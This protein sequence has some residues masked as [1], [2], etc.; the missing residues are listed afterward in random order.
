MQRFVSYATED[1]PI[2]LTCCS[3][4]A[5]AMTILEAPDTPP[6]DTIVTDL[7]LPGE[8]GLSFLQRLHDAPA[9]A[10]GARIVA[11]SAGID[12]QT[13]QQLDALGVRRQL[14]KPISVL[15]LRDV[16]F[17]PDPVEDHD[18]AWP[19]QG[20][21]DE[22][23]GG[24]HALFEAFANQ[25]RLQFEHDIATGDAALR[26]QNV[27]FLHEL[28]HSLKSTMLLLGQP[29]CHAQSIALERAARTSK[30]TQEIAQHWSM[31]RAQLLALTDGRTKL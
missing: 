30:D 18:A 27:S 5:Q 2:S 8:S 21:V 23:F 25:C 15:A 26:T 11:L 3:T 24:Q 14:L 6:F 9:L 22:Y 20:T 13:S 31:L 17:G 29:A 28:A 7:M 12:T 4:V 10:A 16:L 1:D 19:H